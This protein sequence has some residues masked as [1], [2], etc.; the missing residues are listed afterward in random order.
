MGDV[1]YNTAAM[2]MGLYSGLLQQIVK[3]YGFEKALEMHG[4]MGYPMGV[5][6]GEELKKAAHGGKPTLG[7]IEAVNSQMMSSF[8]TTFK[9]SKGANTVKYEVSRCPMYDSYKATGFSDEQ[10]SRLCGAMAPQEY[11]GINSVVQNVSGR[12]KV[13]D[14]PKGCCIEEFIV[15]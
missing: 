1:E 4:N 5:S 2:V 8:G 7:N 14:G 13:R 12:V 10:I 9:V 15:Q 11:A 3:E 6:S